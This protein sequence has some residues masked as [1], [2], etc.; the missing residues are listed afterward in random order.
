MLNLAGKYAN[1]VSKRPIASAIAGGLGAAGL[2]TAG[3]ILSGEA[4][5]EGAARTGL[6]ALGAG[7]LGAIAGAQIPALRGRAGKFYR[8][9]GNVSLE[10]PGAQ[11][12]KAKMSPQEVQQA[13]FMRD[14]LNET[15]RTGV[16][17][18]QLR[19]E[20]KTSV[21]RMQ[22]GINAVTIPGSILAAG[23]AG[24]ML[25]GGIA[26]VGAAVGLPIDPESYGSNNTSMARMGVPTMQY[27]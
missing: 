18:D 3:N 17:A 27:M 21:R 26:N 10:N 22:T 12:R 1:I 11:A 7:A 20:L 23:A 9:I 8:D 4:E 24:G 6:E 5:Q 19:N 16:P 14:I 25:G 2:A 13:E 15:V